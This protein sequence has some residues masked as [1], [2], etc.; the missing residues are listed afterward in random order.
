MNRPQ[1]LLGALL[2][3]APLTHTQAVELNEDFMLQIDAALVSDYRTRGIS[4]TKGDPAAQFGLT[5]QHVSGLYAGAWTSNVDYG[6]G[7]DTR[8]EVDYYAGWYWQATE[9]VGLDLGYIQYRYP[10]ESQFDQSEVYAVLNAYGFEVGAYYSDDLPTYFG[11]NQSNLYSYVGYGFDLPAEFRAKLRLG[12]NDAKDPL[13]VS[14]DGDTRHTYQ[15]WEARLDRDFAG[16]DWSVSY[17][18]TDLSQNECYNWQGFKDVCT[19][20]V[21]ARATKQ[22]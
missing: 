13:Y 17:I 7:Y 9:D 22:F 2:A 16:I 12:R 1:W 20:T 5:L 21:V 18:D 11:R 10:K 3:C 19:A 8:Q 4:Q 15:E 14:G 6:Y